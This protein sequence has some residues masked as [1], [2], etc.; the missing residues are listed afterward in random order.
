MHTVIFVYTIVLILVCFAAAMFSLSAYAVS[1]KRSLIPQAAFFVFYIIDICGIFGIEFLNQNI[2]FSVDT[3]YEIPI[4]LLR[5]L[6]GTGVM[7]C[8]WVMLLD[9]LDV[10]DRRMQ[11]IRSPSLCLP[12]ASSSG[13]FR[14]VPSASGCST[15]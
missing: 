6:S 10:H 15:R 8:L 9:I 13:A 14:T 3:Y 4:P 2:P 5:I 11:I 7:A 12:A 1:H